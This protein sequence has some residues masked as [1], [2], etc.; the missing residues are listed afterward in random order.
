MLL[1]KKDKKVKVR[2]RQPWKYTTTPWDRSVFDP[3]AIFFFFIKLGRGLLDNVS[4]KEPR[5]FA[6]MALEKKEFFLYILTIKDIRKIYVPKAY[7]V[8]D[9]CRNPPDNVSW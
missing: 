1:L 8:N 3:R 6:F 2:F 7:S 5:L 4:C 9:L